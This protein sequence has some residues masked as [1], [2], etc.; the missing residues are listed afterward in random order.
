MGASFRVANLDASNFNAPGIRF[1]GREGKDGDPVPEKVYIDKVKWMAGLLDTAKADLIG[2]AIYAPDLAH[3]LIAGPTGPE[4]R[5]PFCGLVTRFRIVAQEAILAFPDD[6]TGK[7]LVPRSD[8]SADLVS[9]PIAQFQRPVLRVD[10]ELRPET[11]AT[12]F[13]AHLESKT[14]LIYAGED[15]DDPVVQALGSARSLIIR[16]AEAAALRSLIV[17]ASTGNHKPIILLGDLN[18]DLG[19]VTTQMIAGDNSRYEL[20][21]HIFVSEELVAQNPAH[22]AEVKDTRLY[23]DHLFDSRLSQSI[24]SHVT[25]RACPPTGSIVYTRTVCTS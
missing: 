9:I 17:A 12:V 3:N 2:A 13:V 23:N 15:R 19:S 1:A 5:G 24:G 21:D 18:D 25:S 4:A 22:I 7:L 8:G 16:A 11:I 20:L 6:V 10:V 14:E